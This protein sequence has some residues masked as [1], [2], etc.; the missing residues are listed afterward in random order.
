MN[1]GF[2][3]AGIFHKREGRDIVKMRALG[4]WRPGDVG[5]GEAVAAEVLEG[6]RC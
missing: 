4:T 1:T 6:R 2:V 5:A 3:A